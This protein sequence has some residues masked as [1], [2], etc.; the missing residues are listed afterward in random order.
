MADVKRIG[1][2]TPGFPRSVDI[3]VTNTTSR[4]FGSIGQI[5]GSIIRGNRSDAVTAM[6]ASRGMD[7]RAAFQTVLADRLAAH[8]LAVVPEQAS[9]TRRDFLPTY[10]GG[11][12]RDAILDTV[13]SQYGFLALDDSDSSPFRPTVLV[14]TRLTSAHDRSV[15][16]VDTVLINGV[17]GPALAADGTALGLATF[18]DFTELE[19]SPDRAVAS[20]RQAFA[21]AAD[22]VVARLT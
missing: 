15:L 6:M 11:G 4:Y 14:R 13:V 1:M 2:P 10:A 3:V 20:L 12:D 16:M 5:T 7:P 9:A 21:A 8:R 22:G 18:K 19:A 17:Q